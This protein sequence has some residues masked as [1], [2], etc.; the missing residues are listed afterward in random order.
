[1]SMT[2]IS[3][4]KSAEA[5]LEFYKALTSGDTGFPEIPDQVARDIIEYIWKKTYVRQLFPWIRMD[6]DTVKWYKESGTVEVYSPA[7]EGST[8][9]ESKVTFGTPVTMTAKEVRAWTSITDVASEE[10]KIDVIAQAVRHLGKKFAECEEKN[11]LVGAGDGSNAYNL[12]KGLSK[13]TSADGAQV[14]NKDKASISLDDVDKALSYFEDQ[15]YGG[16]G[17]VM[18]INPH[19]AYYLRKSLSDKG[20]D[21][22]SSRVITS[23]EL[24]TIYGI[25]IVETSFLARYDYGDGTMVSDVVICNPSLAAVG[26]DRRTIMIERDRDIKAGLTIIAASERFAWQILRADAVYILQKVLSQ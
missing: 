20:L 16:D 2:K 4:A 9:T 23:G 13:L 21:T 17:L 19:A 7:S 14:V 12:F 6:S 18:F 11:A 3:F 26:G 8:V 10:A 25:K 24:P 22:L 5:Y 1:M 15:G